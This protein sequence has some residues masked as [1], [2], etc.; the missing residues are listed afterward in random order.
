MPLTASG[1]KQ[2]EGATIDYLE[3]LTNGDHHKQDDLSETSSVIANET[4]K[5]GSDEGTNERGRRR[6]N[7]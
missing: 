5:C 2:D 6:S 7:K 3:V 1:A 4:E